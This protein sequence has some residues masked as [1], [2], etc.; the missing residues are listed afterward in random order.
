MY[1]AYAKRD[2]WLIINEF[3]ASARAEL[4]IDGIPP[5]EPPCSDVWGYGL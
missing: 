4:A 2:V 3:V 5:P 1:R